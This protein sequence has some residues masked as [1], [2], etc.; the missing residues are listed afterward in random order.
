MQEQHL[1]GGQLQQRL[2]HSAIG[3][4]F[5]RELRVGGPSVDDFEHVGTR[6]KLRCHRCDHGRC[7]QCHHHVVDMDVLH[8]EFQKGPATVQPPSAENQ[9]LLNGS[10]ESL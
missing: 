6:G 3:G 7:G 10:P 1:L 8:K 4:G 2:R 9:F 5:P